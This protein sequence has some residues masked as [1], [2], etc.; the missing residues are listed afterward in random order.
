M[1]EKCENI[2]NQDRIS[3]NSRRNYMKRILLAMTLLASTSAFTCTEDGAEGFMPEN[4][5]SI[6]VNDK[7]ANDMTEEKF[8]AI[9]TKVADVYAPII[10]KRKGILQMKRKWKNNTVNASAQR[11]GPLYIVNMYGGLARH[12]DVTADG[13]ALVVCHEL[14]HHI[15]GA[16]KIGTRWASNEGQADY[17]GT[18][19]CFRRAF[20]GDDNRTIVANMEIDEEAVTQCTNAWTSEDEIA[21]CKRSA[22]AG[23]SLS[24]LLGRGRSVNFNTPDRTVVQTT[25]DRHPQG[26]C[27]LD[28][29]F[30]GSLC[31]VDVLTDVSKEDP[32]TG[33]CNRAAGNENGLRPLCWFKPAGS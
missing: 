3:D 23:K 30:Q 18:L 29:Y 2:E 19:K 26:Q 20:G 14:G 31:G 10:K 25:N 12:K 4:N 33:T 17:F 5:M 13:F 9:I 7:M 16:P 24:K 27:R 32:N 6:S 1:P 11:L 28:T 22:M 8:N 21:L 15:G